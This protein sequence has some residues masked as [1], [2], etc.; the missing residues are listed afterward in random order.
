VLDPTSFQGD[1][2]AALSSASVAE[3]SSPVQTWIDLR[4]PALFQFITTCDRHI[5]SIV[6]IPAMTLATNLNVNPEERRW[7]ANEIGLD[8]VCSVLGDEIRSALD[9]QFRSDFDSRFFQTFPLTNSFAALWTLYCPELLNTSH[10][11]GIALAHAIFK[12]TMMQRSSSDTGLRFKVDRASAFSQS[13]PSLTGDEKKLRLGVT[14]V[15]FIGEKTVA[16]S[17][18]VREWFTEVASQISSSDILEAGNES[19]DNREMLQAVGRFMALSLIS[20]NPVSVNL[21]TIFHAKLLKEELELSDIAQDEPAL[22]SSLT[23]ILSMSARDFE[24]E[25]IEVDIGPEAVRVSTSNRKE[26][27]KRIL[28][29][30]ISTDTSES[31]EIIIQGFLDVIPLH[32]LRGVV[33]AADLRRLLSGEPVISVDDLRNHAILRDYSEESNQIKWLWHSLNALPPDDLK[34][35]LR[36][37][38]CSTQVPVGGFRN[39]PRR[40]VISRDSTLPPEFPSSNAC[41]YQLSLP[42]YSNPQDLHEKLSRAIGCA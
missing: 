39:M 29:S 41:L 18:S 35:F 11:R 38:T 13:V 37:V 20:R 30:L 9:E 17:G 4:G 19:P 36:F 26:I 5:L 16:G 8:T 27:V 12:L 10:L 28:S 6:L 7:F 32:L 1:V 22:H 15:I 14:R 33:R 31:F 2:I 42:Q 40:I 3:A 34:K 24:R 25:R 23:E 21:P